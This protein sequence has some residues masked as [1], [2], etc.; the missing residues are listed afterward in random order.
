MA[1]NNELC[2]FKKRGMIPREIIKYDVSEQNKTVKKLT[3]NL[4]RCR[5]V[6]SEDP[7]HKETSH[8]N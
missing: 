2:M 4:S 5:N 1:K 8:I 6:S 3:I 7:Q